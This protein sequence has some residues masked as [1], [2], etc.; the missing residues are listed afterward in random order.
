MSYT[1]SI[2]I[3]Y[4]FPHSHPLMGFVMGG[5]HWSW[6]ILWLP[7]SFEPIKVLAQA[8]KGPKG[9]IRVLVP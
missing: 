8:H 2:H 1:I 6:F 9:S 3:L 5:S 7:V 4:I